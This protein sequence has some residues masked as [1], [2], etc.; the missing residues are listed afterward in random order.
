[1]R[2]FACLAVVFALGITPIAAAQQQHAAPPL[3]EELPAQQAGVRMVMIRFPTPVL[4]SDADQICRSL[5]YAGG[6]KF[7][8]EPYNG[9]SWVICTTRA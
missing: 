8:D 6:A 5:N 3:I 7:S 4:G 9:I 2:L 1:M